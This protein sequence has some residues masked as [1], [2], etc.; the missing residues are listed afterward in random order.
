MKEKRL[1]VGPSS[2]LVL[3]ET[4]SVDICEHIYKHQLEDKR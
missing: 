2:P 3:L 4:K 1:T